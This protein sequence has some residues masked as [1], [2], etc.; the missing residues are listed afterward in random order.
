MDSASSVLNPLV[1]GQ[2]V[3]QLQS[4]GVS[5]KVRTLVRWHFCKARVSVWRHLSP[6]RK[7]TLYLKGDPFDTPTHQHKKFYRGHNAAKPLAPNSTAINYHYL[8]P[9]TVPLL[10]IVGCYSVDACRA[11]KLSYH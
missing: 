11:V 10:T 2:L 4:Y 3:V 1:D 7:W 5:V 9:L 8:A 6:A